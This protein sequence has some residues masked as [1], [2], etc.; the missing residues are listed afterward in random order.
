MKISVSITTWS[1]KSPRERSNISATTDESFIIS[2]QKRDSRR[3]TARHLRYTDVQ[4]AEDVNTKKN[5][6]INTM[7][8]RTR[9]KTK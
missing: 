8:I 5:V 4:T 3:D 1:V 2:G 9:T 6:F 7:R